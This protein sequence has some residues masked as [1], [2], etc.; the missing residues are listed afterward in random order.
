MGY[1]LKNAR[2]GK[3]YRKFQNGQ[4]GA[5]GITEYRL[6]SILN[7]WKIKRI[8]MGNVAGEQGRALQ[9]LFPYK[10]SN[11]LKNSDCHKISLLN[12]GGLKLGH[13]DIFD[14][15]FPSLKFAKLWPII[16]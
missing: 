3:R 1:N 5:P 10:S 6:Y 8:C 16:L 2:D 7:F 14:M 9:Q 4:V 11:F 12:D 15:L 13:F